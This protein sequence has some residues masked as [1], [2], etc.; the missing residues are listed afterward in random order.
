MAATAYGKGLH[1]GS[2][3]HTLYIL[4]FSRNNAGGRGWNEIIMLLAV[5]PCK[6]IPQETLKGEKN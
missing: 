6:L 3:I 1:S 2:I 4:G 5:L